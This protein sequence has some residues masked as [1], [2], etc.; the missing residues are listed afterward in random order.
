[1]PL[2]TTRRTLLA[3]LALPALASAQPRPTLVL[4]HGAWMGAAV[5]QR[6]AAALAAQGFEVVAPELPA[7]GAD[8]TPPEAA[9]LALYVEMVLRAMADRPDVVLVGHSFGGIVASAVAEHAAPRVRRIIYVAGYVPASGESA[10]VLS[11]RDPASLVGRYWRQADP[12]RNSPASIAAEGIVETFCADCSAAD[13]AWLVA[14][15]RAEPVPPLGTPVALTPARF[16]AVAKAYVLTTQDRTITPALQ[17]AML[18]AAGITQVLELPTAHTPMLSAPD[19]LARAVAE[20]AL[21]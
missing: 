16:G 14:N 3:T 13:S 15:H 1:M 11:Q 12:A 9:T 5:W 19:A 6:S 10:Y 7:H 18:Q 17:R 4:V 21:R 20:L 2:Q 8:T